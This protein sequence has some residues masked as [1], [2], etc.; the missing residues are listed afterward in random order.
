MRTHDIGRLFWHTVHLTG[1]PPV[2]R[3][4]TSMTEPPYY[5]ARPLIV[6]LPRG[7]GLA[8]GWWRK[9]QQLDVTA[10]LAGALSLRPVDDLSL[11]TEDAFYGADPERVP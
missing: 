11:P 3:G 5:W 9:H 10:H 8:I 7:R 2:H 6:A 4:K 1:A